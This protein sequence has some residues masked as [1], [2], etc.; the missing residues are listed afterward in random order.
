MSVLFSVPTLTNGIAP[1]FLR[2]SVGDG[3]ARS[4]GDLLSGR[5]DD[6]PAGA[7]CRQALAVRLTGLR[8]LREAVERV[9]V[10]RDLGLAVGPPRGRQPRPA[11]WRAGPPPRA[12]GSGLRRTRWRL[13][14]GGWGA[15]WSPR[16]PR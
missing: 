13:F 3:R 5:R 9:A 10:V 8:V 14:S 2:L 4:A 7:E 11:P 15:P 16:W 6:E 12:G 1:S